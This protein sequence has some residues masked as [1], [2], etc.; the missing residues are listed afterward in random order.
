MEERILLATQKT[1]YGSLHGACTLLKAFHKEI[2]SDAS[3]DFSLSIFV[4]LRDCEEEIMDIKNTLLRSFK[5]HTWD[6]FGKAD[7]GLEQAIYDALKLASSQE[8]DGNV[9]K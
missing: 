2:P 6:R 4:A 9:G 3:S 5:K 1:S 7:Q 8:E